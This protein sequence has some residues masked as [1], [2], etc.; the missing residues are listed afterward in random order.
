MSDDFSSSISLLADLEL[1]EC[2]KCKNPTETSKLVNTLCPDCQKET[3]KRST[4]IITDRKTSPS[5]TR[6]PKSSKT[7]KKLETRITE[8]QILIESLKTKNEELESRTSL[9]MDRIQVLEK[10]VDIPHDSQEKIVLAYYSYQK[11]NHEFFTINQVTDNLILKIIIIIETSLNSA[12][13]IQTL[14]I[15]G[16]NFLQG[17]KA[18]PK[19]DINNYV[20]AQAASFKRTFFPLSNE[21]IRKMGPRSFYIEILSETYTEDL[22]PIYKPTPTGERFFTIKSTYYGETQVRNR[23]KTPYGRKLIAKKGKKLYKVIFDHYIMHNIPVTRQELFNHYK[24]GK[25]E[26]DNYKHILIEVGLIK[27]VP[28]PI[29]ERY[30]QNRQ[31]PRCEIPLQP[32]YPAIRPKDLA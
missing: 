5:K 13:Q 1:Q 32:R 9:L 31:I 22:I 30:N 24:L 17:G 19:G 20:R 28:L 2:S 16:N 25:Y 10:E 15:I 29:R 23:I 3:L 7:M 11:K 14:E 21:R 18:T 12:E 8:Q 6:K 26:I 27:K 4:P